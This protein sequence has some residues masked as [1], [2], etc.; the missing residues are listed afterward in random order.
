MTRILI[1]KKVI[2]FYYFYCINFNWVYIILVIL[3]MAKNIAEI[4]TSAKVWD[5][6]VEKHTE[7]IDENFI[8]FPIDDFTDVEEELQS[9]V[10]RNKLVCILKY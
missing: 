8:Q 3:G 2:L 7:T 10:F 1:I 9:S 6:Y 5:K 4:K